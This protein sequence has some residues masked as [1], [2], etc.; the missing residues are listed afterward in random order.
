MRLKTFVFLI[1]VAAV[2]CAY[3]HDFSSMVNGQRLYFDIT[4]KSKN[5]VAVTY[6]GSIKD[7]KT[8]DV[9]GSL[10]IPSKVK[11]D[12]KVYAVTA[13]GPKAFAGAKGLKGISIPSG[14]TSIGDF[15]FEN[16]DSLESVVFPGNPVVIGQG[17][18]FNDR[19]VSNVTIGSDWIAI[20]YS[21]FRWSDSL[22]TINVP[23]KI[24]KIQGVKK[25]KHLNAITVDANN[26]KFSSSDG[27][28]FNKEGTILFACPRAYKGDL[29]VK[30]GTEKIQ[31]GALIDCTEITSLVFPESLESVSFRET[32]RMKRLKSITM[33]GGN[34]VITGF[35][36]GKGKFLFQLA[37]KN[38]TIIVPAS[39]KDK[40]MEV[41]ATEPGE[42]RESPNGIPYMVTPTEIPA[43]KSIK[44]L[45]NIIKK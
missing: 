21:M 1:C 8:S 20:D 42:Y 24:S 17:I 23:A 38:T 44:G 13:I 12:N 4:N 3:S 30:D 10:D 5:T 34:P 6:P 33:K 18:F 16:C 37:D 2:S 40:Y 14:V 11:Y 26:R 39:A 41:L 45:K 15:A 25:L 29:C 43:K 35:F 27:M 19:A 31:E 32:S 36:D 22:K 9:K 7:K 28:L